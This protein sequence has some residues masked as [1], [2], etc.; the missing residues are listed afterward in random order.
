MAEHP[1]LLQRP[2]VEEGDRAVLARPI[3]RVRE[4]AVT[5]DEYVASLPEDRRE[6]IAAVRDAI[7]ANLQPGFEEA[8]QY[9]MVSWIVPLERYPDTYN[10]QALAIAA[11]ASQKRY[12]A[13][14]LMRVRRRR[15]DFRERWKA[16]GRKLDMGKSCVRFKKLEDV[17]LDVVGETIAATTVEGYIDVYERSRAG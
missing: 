14:Y 7:N 11:L 8:M 9:G 16:T 5:P 3:E 13:L 6:A 17:A 2:V 10:G 1:A 12:M 4:L 15:R